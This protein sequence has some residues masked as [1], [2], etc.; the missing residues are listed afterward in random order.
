MKK[1]FVFLF[2]CVLL[3]FALYFNKQPLP[4]FNFYQDG[5]CEFAVKANTNKILPSFVQDT[6]NGENLFVK[7][8]LKLGDYLQ[9]NLNDILGVTIIINEREENVLKNLQ[10][11]ICKTE[12]QND[13]K[14]IFGFSP[15]FEKAIFIE[16]KKCNIHIVVQSDRLV[17]GYPIVLGSY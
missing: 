11:K 5:V 1:I 10:V 14:H 9:K 6:Q 7:A 17:I 4:L 16:N 12:K 2:L 15:L 3:S 13:N 8:P